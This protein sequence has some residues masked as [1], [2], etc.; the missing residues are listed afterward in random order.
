M[1]ILYNVAL[2][3]LEMTFLQVMLLLLHGM[4]KQIG[5]SSLYLSMGLIFAFTQVIGAVGLSIETGYTGFDIHISSGVL[6]LPFLGILAVVYIADGTFSAQRVIIGLMLCLGVSVYIS[7]LTSAQSESLI[8]DQTNTTA[9]TLLSLILKKTLNLMA[10]TVIALT[11]DL[12]LLPIFYQ[13]LR[14]LRINLYLCIAT[15]L[16]GVELIDSVVVGI[17]S[18][19][20][21][22]YWW[23]EIQ[24]TYVF[25]ALMVL[26]LSVILTFYLKRIHACLPNEQRASLDIFYAFFQNYSKR[27]ELERT[28]KATEERYAVLFRNAIANILV[29]TPNG[30]ISEVNESTIATFKRSESD[31]VNHSFLTITGITQETWTNLIRQDVARTSITLPS[32][33]IL[34]IILNHISLGNTPMIL[35]H[36]RDVTEI[37]R[38]EQEHRIWQEKTFHR[39]RLA[40]IG[41]LAGGIAHDFNNFLHAIQGH[42]DIIQY[43]HPVQDEQARKHIESID[44]ISVKASTLT[45]QLLGFARRGKYH[46]SRIELPSFLESTAA[47]FHPVSTDYNFVMEPPVPP[48]APD[49][50]PAVPGDVIQLQQV[51]MNILMNAR[52][53][54]KETPIYD[55]LIAMRYGLAEKLGIRPVP[56]LD[57]TILPDTPYVVISIRDNGPGIPEDIADKVFEPFFTTKAVGEGT[58]MG[59]SMAYG[60][61]ISHNGW[62]QLDKPEKGQGAI[63]SLFL[64]LDTRTLKYYERTGE[65]ITEIKGQS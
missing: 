50:I 23:L 11:A 16:L 3:I 61:L 24:S 15:S 59:L 31:I 13:G 35:I 34:E 51:L 30:M 48:I 25:K 21:T 60:I 2:A 53:A 57:A 40:S 45:K 6:M 7:L 4:R 28:L 5:I 54:Q 44:A 39:E 41:E 36:G 8:N 55:R 14:N 32:G 33:T 43:M 65:K 26:W 52:D 22:Q 47:M 49:D 58:G 29:M 63:F 42:L 18:N 9:L 64:P 19:W 62:I 37:Q 20:G 1:D 46:V 56:P 12:F 10:A 38:M 17:V 27:V